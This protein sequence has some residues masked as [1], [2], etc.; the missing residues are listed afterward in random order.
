MYD[1]GDIFK[2]KVELR[3]ATGDPL[4][5][6]IQ[7]G[8]TAGSA[9]YADDSWFELTHTFSAYGSG[10]RTIYW[11]DGGQDGEYWAGHYGIRMDEASL[12]LIPSSD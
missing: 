12:Q 6:W 8:E 3:D 2:L 7:N 5:S 1:G 4:A 9:S 11:E 10:L